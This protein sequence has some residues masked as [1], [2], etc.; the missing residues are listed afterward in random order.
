[1]RALSLPFSQVLVDYEG[2]FSWYGNSDERQGRIRVACSQGSHCYCFVLCHF[3]LSFKS[4]V[5]SVSTNT[6]IN[7]K[8]MLRQDSAPGLYKHLGLR[9]EGVNLTRNCL[10]CRNHT[11][12][13]MLGSRTW[14]WVLE[15][16]TWSLF[17]S[18]YHLP[19]YLWRA[20]NQTS[21]Q[22]MIFFPLLSFSV[23]CLLHQ[24]SKE[25][26]IERNWACTT[27]ISYH[28]PSPTAML[29]IFWLRFCYQDTNEL[30]CLS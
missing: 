2:T 21:G 30:R 11:A 6:A 17:P 20:S 12:Y 23:I 27:G 10:L 13:F 15:T 24:S 9:F 4:P 14:N 1:M 25:K 16:R 18:L 22:G 7:C 19:L 28:E 29:F 5:L 8:A 3:N 26:V